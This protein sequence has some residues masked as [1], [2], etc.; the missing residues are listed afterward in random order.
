[1]R[2]FATGVS[3]P[4]WSLSWMIA[5]IGGVIRI[6]VGVGVVTIPLKFVYSGVLRKRRFL[7]PVVVRQVERKRREY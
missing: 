7:V 4:T 3:L 5:G 2:L 6:K 1:V